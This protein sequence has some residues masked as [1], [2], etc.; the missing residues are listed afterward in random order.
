MSWVVLITGY[1]DNQKCLVILDKDIFTRIY[2]CLHKTAFSSSL[3]SDI[4]IQLSFGQCH[5]RHISKYWDVSSRKGH[6]L[7]FSFH[8]DEMTRAKEAILEYWVNL[9]VAVSHDLEARRKSW[10]LEEFMN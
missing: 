3:P 8:T 9:G 6:I 5:I 10:D 1:V 2:G 4:I 7:P